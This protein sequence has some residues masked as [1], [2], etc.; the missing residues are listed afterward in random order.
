[1]DAAAIRS[2]WATVPGGRS[3][4]VHIL[5]HLPGGAAAGYRMS[6]RPFRAF[7]WPD[8][9]Y[10]TLVRCNAQ[11]ITKMFPDNFARHCLAEAAFRDCASDPWRSGVRLGVQRG[12]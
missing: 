10:S 12:V 6:S 3:P 7:H 1:M 2:A 5:D 4:L 9:Q 8:A 11:C